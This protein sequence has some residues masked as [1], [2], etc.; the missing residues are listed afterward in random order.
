MAHVVLGGVTVRELGQHLGQFRVDGR[1]VVAL[2]EVLDDELPVG[3]HVVDD[4][5]ADGEAVDVVPLDRLDVAQTRHDIAD[6]LLLEGGRVLRQAHPH[7]AE[8]LP[9]GHVHQAVLGTADVGHPGEIGRRDQLAVQA[10]R[11]GVVRALEGPLDLAGLLRAQLGATVPADIEVRA[12]RVVPRPGDEDA[13]APHVD[14]AERAGLRQF[15]GARD[16]EPHGLEYALLLLG[17]DRRIRV[18][19]AGE[20]G[21]QAVRQ[22]GRG[23]GALLGRT[24]WRGHSRAGNGNS[25]PR[26]VWCNAAGDTQPQ[27]GMLLG[28]CQD[29]AAASCLRQRM[30]DRGWFIPRTATGSP[31]RR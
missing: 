2:H 31:A 16:T 18:G 29:A 4:P 20:R 13:L 8:P 9:H 12:D 21:D 19:G 24:S 17:E 30:N 28:W 5:L 11:P 22:A 23:H 25:G 3:L 6:D 26:C 7:I 1:A 15:G 14:S 10:V 27:H